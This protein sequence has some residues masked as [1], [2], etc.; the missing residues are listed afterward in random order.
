MSVY[1]LVVKYIIR[2]FCVMTIGFLLVKT[3]IVRKDA[4]KYLSKILLNIVLPCVIVNIFQIT[5]NKEILHGLILAFGVA[6]VFNLI[7][8][9]IPRIIKKWLKLSEVEQ[10]SLS[11]PNSGE[12]LIPLV[13]SIMSKEMQVYCCAF[14][15]VQLCFIFTHGEMLISKKSKIQLKNI[16]KNKNI[17]AIALGLVL[18]LTEISLP[19]V[20]TG[21]LD[22]FST[23]LAPACMLA[24]GISIGDCKLKEI[25]R[26]KRM[27]MICF[28]RLI[29]LPLFILLLIRISRITMIM[30]HA[31][32]IVLIVFMATASST[33]TTVT[34]MAYCYEI[35]EEQAS[36]ISIMSVLFLIITLPVMIKLYQLVV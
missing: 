20:V 30:E 17:I 7:L 25:L 6:I 35:D 32:N 18:F 1:I 31:K 21:V 5:Y 15:I 8:L 34:N 27:Y 11:Y 22:F 14:L 16:L 36:F 2:M 33:S 12:I 3:K 19:I 26:C 13:V 4:G 29:V 28:L 24:I 10:A 23:M 9:L